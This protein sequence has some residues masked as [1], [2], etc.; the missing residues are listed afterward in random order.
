M[1]EYLDRKINHM[2]HN[3][4]DLET[5]LKILIGNSYIALQGVCYDKDLFLD[6]CIALAYEKLKEER[7]ED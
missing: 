7:D 1:K 4:E 2:L 5:T 6:E 3:D